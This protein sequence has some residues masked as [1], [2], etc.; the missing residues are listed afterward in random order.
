MADIIAGASAPD[1]GVQ[2][3]DFQAQGNEWMGLADDQGDR[4]NGREQPRLSQGLRDL[5]AWHLGGI[6]GLPPMLPDGQIRHNDSLTE[7]SLRWAREPNE[8]VSRFHLK[9]RVLAPGFISGYECALALS[10]EIN[11]IAE[12]IAEQHGLAPGAIEGKSNCYH[13]DLMWSREVSWP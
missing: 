10:A 1:S 9:V 2:V 6:F 11:P 5:I 3:T 7:I 13:I 4:R 8:D 12:F